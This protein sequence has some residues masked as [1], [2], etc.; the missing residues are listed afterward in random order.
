NVCLSS[1]LLLL[2]LKT[3]NVGHFY[4]DLY[5]FF[6]I[7]SIIARPFFLLAIG[8]I[9]YTAIVHPITY[10]AT[11]SCLRWDWLVIT[12][13]WIYTLAIAVFIIFKK[14]DLSHPFFF[15]LFFINFAPTIFF[16]IATLRALSSSGP[17]NGSQTLNLAKRKAFRIILSILMVLLV[18]YV[19]RLYVNLYAVI[20]PNDWN[21]LCYE[22]MIMLIPKF[23]EIAMPVIFLYSLR[24]LGV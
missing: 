7:P 16:N 21:F 17:G 22:V 15:I 6:Q 24:K 8:A 13:I 2:F 9:F 14:L 18:Y 10:M 5:L 4:S 23:A 20:A 12:L 3:I 11:K 1:S 19:P